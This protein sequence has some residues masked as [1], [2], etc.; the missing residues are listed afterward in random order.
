MRQPKITAQVVEDLDHQ[1]ILMHDPTFT[2]LHIRPVWQEQHSKDNLPA[3]SFTL[4]ASHRW[5][6]S[7]DT[8][9]WLG[10]F[11]ETYHDEWHG[12][13]LFWW[14]FSTRDTRDQVDLFMEEAWYQARQE[15]RFAQG[16][17]DD[18]A[19]D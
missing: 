18:P 13:S 7:V 6:M 11:H 17:I 5:E 16:E 9:R 19:D 3:D 2:L 8:R 15:W 10:D 14:D 1:V 4:T 12:Y